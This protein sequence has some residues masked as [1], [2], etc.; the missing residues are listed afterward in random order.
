M[1]NVKD[2]EPQHCLNVTPSVAAGSTQSCHSS[3]APAPSSSGKAP[4]ACSTFPV[5]A[6][7]SS[8]LASPAGPSSSARSPHSGPSS[9]SSAPSSPVLAH[10]LPGPAPYSPGPAPCSPAPA[11]CSPAPVQSSPSLAVLPSAS[12]RAILSGYSGAKKVKEK[13]VFQPTKTNEQYECTYYGKIFSVGLLL[14]YNRK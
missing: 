9:P 7:S 4:P 2:P 13:Q 11:P 10:S 12:S 8:V 3:P 6:P 1:K 5:S 14:L